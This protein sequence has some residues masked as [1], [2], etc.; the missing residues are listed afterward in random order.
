MSQQKSHLTH[1]PH[2]EKKIGVT[3]SARLQS[4][5]A[6]SSFICDACEHEWVCIQEWI[7]L[8]TPREAA[9][10]LSPHQAIIPG[11][12][13]HQGIPETA[14]PTQIQPPRPHLPTF[15]PPRP[16]THQP[17]LQQ[18][19]ESPPPQQPQQH[20]LPM[21]HA[22]SFQPAQQSVPAPVQQP[23]PFQ[24]PPQQPGSQQYPAR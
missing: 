3:L 4:G 20:Q 22:W 9:P 14:A 6:G 1:C 10:V 12:Q 2:C 7:Y 8:E 18:T 21:P 13:Q 16:A 17:T 23:N 15:Q 5:R 24:A 11:S 19:H